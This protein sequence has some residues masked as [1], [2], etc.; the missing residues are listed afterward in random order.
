MSPDLSSSFLFPPHPDSV[1][2]W[3]HKSAELLQ[4]LG[5]GMQSNGSICIGAPAK[6]PPAQW[7]QTVPQGGV[8][9]GAPGSQA[10][11]TS[12]IQ[13]T[14][15]CGRRE[16]LWNARSLFLAKMVSDRTIT[17][18]TV[19]LYSRNLTIVN[20]WCKTVAVALEPIST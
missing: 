14:R 17:N 19:T 10:S 5:K 18:L 11:V 20:L 2:H 9:G 13:R 7:H 1:L 3:L 4:G 8:G 12:P 15:T 6:P 16:S